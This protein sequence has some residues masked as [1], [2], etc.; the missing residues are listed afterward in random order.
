MAEGKRVRRI[1][2]EKL[3]RFAVEADG[4]AADIRLSL[5]VSGLE[6]LRLFSSLPARSVRSFAPQGYISSPATS[7]MSSSIA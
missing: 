2:V 5:G 1:Y 7:P 6:A 3:P 4:V